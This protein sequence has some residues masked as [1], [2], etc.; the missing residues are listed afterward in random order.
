MNL[1]IAPYNPNN[2][3]RKNELITA[4]LLNC[5]LNF[6][7]NIFLFQDTLSIDVKHDKII[8]IN[9]NY[10]P[11][12]QDVINYSNT[13]QSNINIICNADISLTNT[14]KN[15]SIN[16][17]DF[18]CITRYDNNILFK[19]ASC[20]QDTWCWKNKCKIK[21]ANFYFGIL[22]CDNTVAGLAK[23][24]GYTVTNPC[25]K[26]KTNHHHQSNIREYD[27]TTRLPRENYLTGLRPI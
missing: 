6:I 5:S 10:R 3:L 4:I 23:K 27:E 2:S 17:N 14:F 15:I 9:L 21:D 26:Y 16:D 24:C 22:G 13:L 18:Y 19:M 12:F 11:T 7:N 20:S 25:K 8:N 1:Y